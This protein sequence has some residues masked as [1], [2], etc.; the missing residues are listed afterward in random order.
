MSLCRRESVKFLLKRWPI[1]C[2]G[3]RGERIVARICPIER[4]EQRSGVI[5]RKTQLKCISGE[6]FYY[7]SNFKVPL[8]LAN[9]S[10]V[11]PEPA[12]WGCQPK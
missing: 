10:S 2:V 7:R 12:L 11:A 9:I 1:W 6:M 4:T 5:A 3:L 8:Q